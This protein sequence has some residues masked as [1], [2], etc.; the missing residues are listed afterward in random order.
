VLEK[1]DDFAKRFRDYL[2]KRSF[3]QMKSTEPAPNFLWASPIDY[4]FNEA[5][6]LN[7]KGLEEND[8]L[9]KVESLTIMLKV[10]IDDMKKGD[11]GKPKLVEVFGH[12]E[13]QCW[14]LTID[15]EG[16]SFGK[17][18]EKTQT[19]PLGIYP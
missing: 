3:L 14:G 16:Y 15:G 4:K 19:Y 17:K 13:C 8:D 7:T 1:S 18:C 10:T 5:N 11:D 2:K 9:K 6:T 12:S